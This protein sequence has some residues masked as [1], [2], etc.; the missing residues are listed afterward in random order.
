MEAAVAYKQ[1]TGKD[2]LLRM[3]CR[4]ADL[5]DDAFGA[6]DGKA[7]G[8]P[9]HP[10][11]ELA[12]VKLYRETGQGRYLQLAQYMVDERG[13]E[14][15]YF[16]QEAAAR[17]EKPGDFWAQTYRYCQ[18]HRPVREHTEATGHAVRACYLYAGIADLAL[19]TKDD[20]L[21]QL[22]RRLWDDLTRHQMYVTGGLGPSHANEGFTHAYDFPTE[23]AYAETCASI[24]LAFWAHRLFHIDPDSRYIDVM[25]R[26]IY[27]GSLSGLS[28]DGEGFFYGN[29]MTA[30][31][32]V[33]PLG[34]WDD[35]TEGDHYRR[36]AW[37]GCP[38]CPPNI[39]RL[40]ASLGEYSY[41]QAGRRVYVQLYHDN[42]VTLNLDGSQLSLRQATSYPW[43]GKI[44]ISVSS[45]QSVD[46]ELALR[47]PDWRR[48]Y[49]LRLNGEA[50]SARLERGYALLARRWSDGDEIELT[51]EMPVERVLPHREIRQ[52][53]GQ[54]ALQRGPLIYC[55][56]EVDNGARLANICLP[57]AAELEAVFDAQLFGGATVIEGLAKRIEAE[58]ENGALYQFQSREGLAMQDVRIRAIPY[59]LWANR[60]AGEMR[61]W[62]RT[63]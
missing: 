53:A 61:V 46:F 13:S 14:P 20:E 32:G 11:I 23:T 34:R 10:E 1:A 62:L 56:E 55:L 25:E 9:G 35:L 36:S 5:I 26:A 59:Y 60:A 37:F 24:A 49:A 12:L 63:D 16:D 4:Y 47:I 8:Y 31:P 28:H 44:A 40:I 17:G 38:C 41:S 43:D 39:S 29:P 52:V 42:T 2:K 58:R 45:R 3:L 15:H 48:D 19:E 7:R 57:E 54:V 21:L 18:A 50:T 27:N 6:D 51:L 33:N 22:S 30:Y